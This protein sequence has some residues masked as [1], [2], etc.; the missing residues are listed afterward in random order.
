MYFDLQKRIFFVKTYY[1]FEF[2]RW[3]LSLPKATENWFICSDEAYFTLTL[4]LNKQNNRIWADSQP[5]IGIETPLH[6]EKVLVWCAISA[7]KIYGPYFF[8]ESVNQD[9]YLSMLKIFFWPKH[10]RTAEYKKYFFQQDGATPHTANTVQTWLTTKFN[11]KFVNKKTWPPRSPDLNP[12]DFYLWGYLKATVYNPLPKTIDELKANI[13]RDCK[14]LNSE[15]LKP[16]FSNLKKRCELILSAD[17]GH[18]EI[19]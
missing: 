19:N 14:K 11:E 17:G 10:L 7:A 3:F 15:I 1:E 9:N 8:S 5:V 12:C 16:V 13:E 2:A 6:D 4:P 18:I